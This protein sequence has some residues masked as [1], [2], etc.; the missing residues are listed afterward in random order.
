MNVRGLVLDSV[1]EWLWPRALSPY[2]SDLVAMLA[3]S[4]DDDGILGYAQLPTAEES[5]AFVVSLEE[6]LYQV[7]A[8]S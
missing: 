5:R 7:V 6:M 3:A 8:M 2:S 1:R 4:V